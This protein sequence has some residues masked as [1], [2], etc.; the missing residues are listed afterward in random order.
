MGGAELGQPCV[1]RQGLLEG[2]LIRQR[3]AKTAR[4]QLCHQ[5]LA[6]H[7]RQSPERQTRLPDMLWQR[8]AQWAEDQDRRNEI[9]RLLY[10]NRK[11][12]ALRRAD[13]AL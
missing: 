9:H 3:D 5:Y 11:S 2:R 7:G 1:I 12:L 6:R 4:S 8:R 13:R 10:E